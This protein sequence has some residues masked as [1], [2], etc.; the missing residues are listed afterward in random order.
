MG[1]IPCSAGLRLVLRVAA[2]GEQAAVHLGMQRLHAAVEHLGKPG[3]V[4]DILHREA[5]ARSAAAVPPVEINST[6]MATSSR[7]NAMSPALVR[8]R[9][10]R[11]ANA[12]VSGHAVSSL[13]V[14]SLA[15]SSLAM[16]AAT[17]FTSVSPAVAPRRTICWGG[18]WTGAF[19]KV[20]T[21]LDGE[22][23]TVRSEAPMLTV[24]QR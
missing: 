20:R 1:A 9:K 18:A 13:A 8:I 15:G 14:S 12:R 6:S 23:G 16:Y 19:G 5:A 2:D 10:Q 22:N 4:R 3:E 11:T 7:A 21:L 24:S 17:Q